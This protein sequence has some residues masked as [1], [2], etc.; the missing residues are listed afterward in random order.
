MSPSP[1]GHTVDP[2]WVPDAPLAPPSSNGGL[3]DV[4]RRRYVLKLL[5]IARR[6][7]GPEG[8]TVAQKEVQIG[9]VD[10]ATGIVEITSGL[11]DGDRVIV[12]NVGTLGRGMQ[13]RVVDRDDRPAVR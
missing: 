13:V 2:S 5:A 7:E 4:F 11:E 9:V 6:L 8:E 3:L 12:G 1:T 10:D